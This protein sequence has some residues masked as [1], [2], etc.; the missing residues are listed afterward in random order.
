MRVKPIIL[1]Y[2]QSRRRLNVVDRGFWIWL[3]RQ[4]KAEL[5]AAAGLAEQ[6][7]LPL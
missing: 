2:D 4:D 7:E 5:L 3:G 1:D 6:N